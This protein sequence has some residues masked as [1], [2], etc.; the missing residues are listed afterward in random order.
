MTRI[1]YERLKTC[2][3]RKLK[4]CNIKI[5]LLCY[6]LTRILLYYHLN[7][8]KCLVYCCYI[9]FRC[10]HPNKPRQVTS[11]TTKTQGK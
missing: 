2:T 7:K 10:F 3:Q 11:I 1:T 4:D 6:Y 9:Y 8:N 5:M